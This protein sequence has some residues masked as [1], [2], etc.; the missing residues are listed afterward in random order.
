MD[1]FIVP[2]ITFSLPDLG[3]WVS[4][5]LKEH[6]CIHMWFGNSCI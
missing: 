2:K 6:L 4:M 3:I 5:T 1:T